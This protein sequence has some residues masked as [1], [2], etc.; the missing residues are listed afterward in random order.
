MNVGFF[1]FY[2]I[3]VSN[4]FKVENVSIGCR[5]SYSELI[6]VCEL[7]D[8]ANNENSSRSRQQTDFKT[9]IRQ[10]C[11]SVNPCCGEL[12]LFNFCINFL[13]KIWSFSS[14]IKV[15]TTKLFLLSI[16]LIIIKLKPQQ[17]YNCIIKKIVSYWQ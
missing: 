6:Q 1:S 10:K 17:K 12:R 5:I 15:E 14:S 16:S 8:F 13:I 3:C 11:S 7:C 2:L 9:L 4:A